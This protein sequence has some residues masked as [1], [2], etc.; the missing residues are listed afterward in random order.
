[1][2]VGTTAGTYNGTVNITV[3]NRA[4]Y[5]LDLNFEVL[6]IQLMTPETQQ[7]MYYHMSDETN[8]VHYQPYSD[9]N[10]Y[11]KEAVNMKEHGMNSTM[12]ILPVMFSG[13]ME[14][15][16]A[17]YNLDPLAPFMDSFMDVGMDTV[18][19]NMTLG[20]LLPYTW[21]NCTGPSSDYGVNVRG[22]VDSFTARGWSLPILSYSDESDA[23]TGWPNVVN[24]LSMSKSYVP[25]SKTYTTIVYPWSS[26]LFEPYLDIRTFSSYIDS[27][28]IG[29]TRAA[30][31]ELW[32]YSGS[33]EGCK[34]GRFYRGIWGAVM[35]LD[36]ILDWTYFE[37]NVYD[38]L[39][40]DLVRLNGA[41]N[42]RGYV[43][44]TPQGPLPTP[45][46][47]GIREGVEDNKYLYTLS[48]LIAQANAS[49]D[50]G[51]ISLATSAQAYLDGLYDQVDDIP[52]A[53]N[54]VSGTFPHQAVCD[55]ITDLEFFDDFRLAIA[56][57]IQA[58]S[59]ALALL[60]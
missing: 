38:G 7:G 52:N 1:M 48:E 41:P 54:P 15:S 27:T 11:Y 18:I 45:A 30:G 36:G 42:H 6:D 56:G 31:R 47:E 60:P 5:S 28:V 13:H 29:P 53:P 22:F 26:E 4:D 12:I 55:T 46:W 34:P 37:L 50:T 8:P 23:G 3:G 10:Y 19:F 59:E 51:L 40:D 9:P 17:V 20:Q 58:I 32:Q 2:P 16:N 14:G 49:G 33:Q 24:W 21:T 39:F 43:F 35:T 44:P 25:E 57:H